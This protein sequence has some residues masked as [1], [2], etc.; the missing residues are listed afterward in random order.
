MEEDDIA[1]FLEKW[2]N[3][4]MTDVIEPTVQNQLPADSKK[5][6][7]ARP[8]VFVWAWFD[9]SLVSILAILRFWLVTTRVRHLQSYSSSNISIIIGHIVKVIWLLE[10]LVW[11]SLRWLKQGS[12]VWPFLVAQKQQFQPR[13]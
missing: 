12:F 7:W 10:W 2:R 4:Q 9:T 13:F 3:I 8:S 11:S 6:K 1:M 5:G